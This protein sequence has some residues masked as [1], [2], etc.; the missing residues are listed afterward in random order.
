MDARVRRRSREFL[1]KRFMSRIAAA[2]ITEFRRSNIDTHV[3]MCADSIRRRVV[4]VRVECSRHWRAT[5]FPRTTR[6]SSRWRARNRSRLDS[7]RTRRTRMHVRDTLGRVWAAHSLRALRAAAALARRRVRRRPPS[8][9]R[10]EPNAIE[11]RPVLRQEDVRCVTLGLRALAIAIELGPLA[12]VNARVRRRSREF[13]TKRFMSRIAAARITESRRS[14]SDTHVSICADSIRRRVVRVRVECS[15]HSLATGFH[16]TTR[17]S[18]RW[19]ARKRSRLESQRTRR[20]RT[21]VRDT[22]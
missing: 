16:R 13:L 6:E 18:S 5:G 3:S 10:V 17:E 19:R 22:H 8:E 2:R 4:R 12:L 21:H 15:R 9:G 7:Q 14:S 11:E 1:T 20:T